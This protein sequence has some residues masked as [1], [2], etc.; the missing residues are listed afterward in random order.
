MSYISSAYGSG[1]PARR[2]MVKE[3]VE[4]LV[5]YLNDNTSTD[6][7]HWDFGDCGVNAG[8]YGD[9]NSGEKE[10]IK[11]VLDVLDKDET[12]FENE[13]VCIAHKKWLWGY[14][15]SLPYTTK[16]GTNVHGCTVY[17]GGS[18]I[19]DWEVRGFTWH[20]AMHSYGADHSDGRYWLNID[21]EMYAITPMAMGYLYNKRGL[22]DTNYEGGDVEPDSFCNGNPN[23][24]YTYR[25]SNLEENH[26]INWLS[27]CTENKA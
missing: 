26:W 24:S 20:E 27:D 13:N 2:G 8:D 10:F 12:L 15:R 9:G 19:D 22:V 1:G 21:D 3:E 23:H 11:D 16:L 14:G 17:A 25:Y 5:T 4:D 18:F 6:Y 7:Y